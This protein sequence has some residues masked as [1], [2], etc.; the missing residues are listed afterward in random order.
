MGPSNRSGF[1]FVPSTGDITLAEGMGPIIHTRSTLPINVKLPVARGLNKGLELK[2]LNEGA[3]TL[4]FQTASGGALSPATTVPTGR[5]G[6][7]ISD[8]AL[9]RGAYTTTS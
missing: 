9:W 8:G 7:L 4:T 3:G 5:Y 6:I 2:I 1:T